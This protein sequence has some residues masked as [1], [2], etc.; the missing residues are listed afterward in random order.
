MMSAKVRRLSE[1]FYKC[2]LRVSVSMFGLVDNCIL[3]SL[4]KNFV[5]YKPSFFPPASRNMW[6][7]MFQL[8]QTG[9]SKCSVFFLFLG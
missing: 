6:N 1:T 5:E 3:S 2:V 9:G 4:L 7:R 8:F